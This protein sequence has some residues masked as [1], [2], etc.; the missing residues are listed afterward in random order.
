MLHSF[1]NWSLNFGPVIEESMFLCAVLIYL[2]I[3]S[4]EELFLAYF[5]VVFL[6]GAVFCHLRILGTEGGGRRLKLANRPQMCTQCSV[7]CGGNP[8]RASS[9]EASLPEP[10]P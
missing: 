6:L 8:P 2:G 7:S 9:Q 4:S 10:R 3:I 5:T 1:V